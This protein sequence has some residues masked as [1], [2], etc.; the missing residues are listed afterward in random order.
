MDPSEHKGIRTDFG[1][2]INKVYDVNQ[3]ELK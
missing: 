2:I 3:E 1:R